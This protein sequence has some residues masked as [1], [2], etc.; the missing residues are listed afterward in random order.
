MMILSDSWGHFVWFRASS[1]TH[2]SSPPRGELCWVHSGQLCSTEQTTCLRGGRNCTDATWPWQT[3]TD[4]DREWQMMTGAAFFFCCYRCHRNRIAVARASMR[5]RGR[6]RMF[7]GRGT[8]SR[9][10]VTAEKDERWERFSSYRAELERG[11]FYWYL[12]SLFYTV[13]IISLQISS[14]LEEHWIRYWVV[15]KK[16]QFPEDTY[17]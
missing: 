7:D 10:E 9:R 15:K 13:I 16:S 5:V 14:L 3:M 4:A 12:A 1:G 17:P 6:M 11:R 2:F 8:K